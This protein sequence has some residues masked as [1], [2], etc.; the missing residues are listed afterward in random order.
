MARANGPGITDRQH[1]FVR[2][3]LLDYNVTQ[4]AIRSGYSPRSARTAGERNMKNEGIRVLIRAGMDQQASAVQVTK[5]WLLNQAVAIM[6]EA[7]QDKAHAA[8]VAANKL[9]A[10][11]SGNL[12]ERREVRQITSISDL[13]DEELRA[14]IAEAKQRPAENTKR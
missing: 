9:T 5:Q 8:A 2:E 4:A 13:T 12:I 3:Y 14:M 1:A 11:L 6:Q 7:R 10:Q